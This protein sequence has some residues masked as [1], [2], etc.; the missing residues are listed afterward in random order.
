MSIVV[1]IMNNF[2]TQGV[3]SF[4]V[5]INN[6]KYLIN[7]PELVQRFLK[8]NGAKVTT[9]L[10][11]DKRSKCPD[12]I[13]IL[14]TGNSSEHIAGLFGLM[15]TLGAKE[16]TSG[17]KVYCHQDLF[18]FIA[19]TKYIFGVGFLNF[20]LYGFGKNNKTG[21]FSYGL[22]C[23]GKLIKDKEKGNIE[24]FFSNY[25]GSNFKDIFFNWDEFCSKM[26]NKDLKDM[27]N[28]KAMLKG[29]SN[30]FSNE[31]VDKFDLEI[32]KDDECEIV[33]IKIWNNNR[34]Q[35]VINYLFITK[36]TKNS[37]N[38]DL[39]KKF[40]LEGKEIGMLKK[41]GELLKEGK[42][43]L[44]SDITFK[45]R[46]GTSFLIL[47]IPDSSFINDIKNNNF[48]RFIQEEEHEFEFKY[49]LNCFNAEMMKSHVDD[50]KEVFSNPGVKHILVSEEFDREYDLTADK[51]Q[52][53][54]RVYYEF[55]NNSLPYIFPKQI[56]TLYNNQHILKN[57]NINYTIYQ[58]YHSLSLGKDLLMYPL[59][60]NEIKQESFPK[61]K[62]F[63]DI[64]GS[65]I[66]KKYHQQLSQT[67]SF[68]N[69]P[70]VVIL[71]TGSMV[72]STYR[73]VSSILY[74]VSE[75]LYFLLDCGEGTYRQLLEQF[76]D[77]IETV[78][79]K[80]KVIAITHLHGDHFYGIINMIAKREETLKRTNTKSTL[81]L[82]MPLNSIPM[83]MSYLKN[84]EASNVVILSNSKLMDVF[85]PGDLTLKNGHKS[86]PNYYIPNYAL[87]YYND[88]Y[89]KGVYE[90]KKEYENKDNIDNFISLL[91]QNGVDEL[92]PVPVDHCPEACG[93]VIRTKERGIVYSGDCRMTPLLAEYGKD[94]DILIH[95]STFDCSV[96]LEEVNRKGHSSIKDAIEIAKMM[97]CGHLCLTHFSQRYS[98]SSDSKWENITLPI[99][100]EYR[101]F[102]FKRSFL[103]QD[104][105]YFDFDCVEFMPELHQLFN[106]F[107]YE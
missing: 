77:N 48:F 71:G 35:Y 59:T 74:G 58:S 101:E 33:C 29:K 42:T 27:N 44:L 10:F 1:K 66:Y 69:F 78:L 39:L 7:A 79:L 104:H 52:Q 60:F 6:K 30:Y 23:Y 4:M 85:R 83:V 64:E 75:D 72:P 92:L 54:S 40:D 93:F 97:N 100:E 34:S 20:S 98:I 31:I 102:F 9:T 12:R 51:V 2:K 28:V 91:K 106:K 68:S 45:D 13:K 24:N 81:Y 96:Q 53:K 21:R 76:G 103:A 11:E 94:C 18:R 107:G 67:N 41:K 38:P 87:N 16:L 73:N 14:I 89:D 86:F 55:L 56:N 88:D 84:I 65:E 62:D 46:K 50:L 63:F 32:I 22:P 17:S 57:L 25:K 90:Y 43:I 26:N 19:D 47:E 99:E 37:I 82:I 80:T 15:S 61:I 36:G 105:L 70:F 5:N 3:T 8:E 95:E 49:I